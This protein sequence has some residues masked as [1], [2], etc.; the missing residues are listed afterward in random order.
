MILSVSWRNVWRSKVRSLVILVAIALG[1]STG[2]FNAAFYN[3]MANQRIETAIA[4]EA[5]HVQLHA[6]GYMEDP[7]ER[8]YMTNAD[9]ICNTIRQWNIVA[10]VSDRFILQSMIQ[11]AATSTGVKLVGVNP[12]QEMKV[13]DIHQHIIEG[14]YFEGVK[15]NPIVIGD[16]LAKKLNVKLR[17]KVVLTFS[18]SRGYI[19]GA[20]FRVAGIYKTTNTSFDGLNV[21]ARSS[22]LTQLYGVNQTD[23]HEVAILC[24]GAD[25]VEAVKEQLKD[26]F[27]DL[28]V[29]DWKQLMPEVALLESSLDLTMY[30]FMIII[31][32]ALV[33]GI[34]NTM[35]MAVL[36]RTKELGMLM[37]IGMNHGRV[38]RMI[39]TETVMLT[40]VGGVVGALLGV[41][42]VNLTGNSGIDISIVSEGLGALGYASVVY[43]VISMEEVIKVI[44]MVFITGLVAA[45]YPARK[46]LRLKPAEAIRIDM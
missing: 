43:P 16:K 46:A 4:T 26:Q 18:D 20:S 44:I 10:A 3:G 21:F 24:I 22:D 7:S 25:Q 11:S 2:I 14:A 35:L 13:T 45:L 5:S 37:A 31:L 19:S 23:A 28:D 30:I 36:E 8:N 27:V 40:L 15:R 9:S 29:Q 32:L 1:I 41:L 17:S 34:I 39:L 6:K 33:F 38:F 12:K 42:A